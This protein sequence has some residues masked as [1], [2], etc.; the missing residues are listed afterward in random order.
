[1]TACTAE[2]RRGGR[3]PENFTVAGRRSR[4][5][6][7]RMR[8]F[9]SRKSALTLAHLMIVI[10][11]LAAGC[12]AKVAGKADANAQ[13]GEDPAGDR[14]AW[15]SQSAVRATLGEPVKTFAEGRIWV[16]EETYN[17]RW[18]TIIPLPT[19]VVP[20]IG[21]YGTET[22]V[23][24]VFEFDKRGKLIARRRVSGDKR[25]RDGVCI[26]LGRPQESFGIVFAT[27]Y[28]GVFTLDAPDW[29]R[30]ELAVEPPPDSC[31]VHFDDDRD[32]AGAWTK[33][34]LDGAPAGWILSPKSYLRWTLPA[35]RHRLAARTQRHSSLKSF[36]CAPGESVYLYF[37]SEDDGKLVSREPV[38]ALK[39]LKK[40]R[41]IL[42]EWPVGPLRESVGKDPDLRLDWL[43]NGE[44]T[45]DDVAHRLGPPHLRL[46][47]PPTLIYSAT[48]PEWQALSGIDLGSKRFNQT[49]L[50]TAEFDASDRLVGWQTVAANTLYKEKHLQGGP[51]SAKTDGRF[52]TGSRTLCT[53]DGICFNGGGAVVQFASLRKNLELQDFA[54]SYQRPPDGSCN[55][56]AWSE[57]PGSNLR[58]SLDG[59]VQG[60]L[61]DSVW[62]PGIFV[63]QIRQGETLLKVEAV[64]D[65]KNIR[66]GSV[67]LRCDKPRTLKLRFDVQDDEARIAVS[68]GLRPP[69]VEVMERRYVPSPA[70]LF[71]EFGP[72]FPG[73]GT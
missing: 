53:A 36:V 2:A 39:E 13:F 33:I 70:G 64:N 65:S 41:L 62:P 72:G 46:A 22:P 1:M 12:T 61:Y 9:T 34:W 44:T 48:A 25:C 73:G 40:R 66:A 30:D 17:G 50:L 8:P 42:S 43:R 51:T 58:L 3:R 68:S 16:Y 54:S 29:Y 27:A 69:R 28:S 5:L 71:G 31:F 14:E 4:S 18:V 32:Y 56:Y 10:G 49:Y 60:Y 35:G 57:A 20:L 21:T 11:F 67:T 52:G 23:F 6:P 7:I 19:S 24:R 47:E 55:V 37:K 38:K 45:S 63:W 15:T 26:S 59:Q